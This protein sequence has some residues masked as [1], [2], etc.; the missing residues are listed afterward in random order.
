MNGIWAI[1]LAAG[2]SRRMG[3]PK[4]LLP[5]N[6][7]TVIEQVIRNL[8]DSDIDRVVIV[9][10]A[11]REKI[12]TVTR[13]YD[14]FHCYN[15]D[16]QTG[17]LSSVKC[18]F[19]SLP[20]GCTGALIMPGDQP[21]TGPGEINRVIRTFL[22]SDKGLVMAAHNGKRGHPLIVDMKYADEVLNL[23]DGEGLRALADRHQEDVLESDT[24]DSSVLRDIDT[25]EDY[26][27]EISKTR[28]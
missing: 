19:Y 18:G 9:L 26:M 27:N 7:V 13:S 10:G 5:Y 11:N 16:Y 24:D 28:E 21:M 8:L 12:M 25:Q 6:D 23:P 1:V 2:E 15:E 4:M 22:E 20:Q 3:S 17:M 14:V